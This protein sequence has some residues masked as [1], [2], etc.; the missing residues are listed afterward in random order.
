MSEDETPYSG[1]VARAENSDVYHIIHGDTSICRMVNTDSENVSI[2]D[3]ETA[4]EFF[5]LCK[6][7]ESDYVVEYDTSISELRSEIG[8]AIGVGAPNGQFGKEHIVALYEELVD[9]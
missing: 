6:H 1:E 4:A 3:G 2:T 7:C 8:D 9:E 5:N